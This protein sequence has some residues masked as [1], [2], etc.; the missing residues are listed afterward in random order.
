MKRVL[1]L[2]HGEAERGSADG[3]DHARAINET[4]RREAASAGAWIMSHGQTP[5]AVFCSTALRARQTLEALALPASLVAGATF[6]DQL[7]LAGTGEMLHCLQQ[8]DD[9]LNRVLLVGHNPGIRD[10]CVMFAQ[11]GD[12]TA[13]DAVGLGFKTAAVAALAFDVPRWADVPGSR[14]GALERYR[15]P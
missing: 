8:V 5:D 14:G 15:A 1:L 2:R 12:E 6:S 13:L 11:Q 3:S 9:T 7:Y 10:F 4:G